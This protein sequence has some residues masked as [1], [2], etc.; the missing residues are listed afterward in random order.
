LHG[1]PLFADPTLK[2]TT[3]TRRQG[4]ISQLKCRQG[5]HW[6]RVV[7]LLLFPLSP[8]SSRRDSRNAVVRYSPKT[9]SLTPCGTSG[10]MLTDGSFGCNLPLGAAALERAEGLK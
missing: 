8:Y 1:T 5:G 3:P 10:F 4:Q 6:P 9:L 2:M 7:R